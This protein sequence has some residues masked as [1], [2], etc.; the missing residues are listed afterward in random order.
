M[1]I[2]YSTEKI[3]ALSMKLKNI[4][5]LIKY[6]NSFSNTPENYKPTLSRKIEYLQNKVGI[7]DS[8]K[9]KVRKKKLEQKLEKL[10]KI[11]KKTSYLQ[12]IS[13]WYLRPLINHF[14][15][16]QKIETLSSTIVG[17]NALE[18]KPMLYVKEKYTKEIRKS[19]LKKLNQFFRFKAFGKGSEKSQ[20]L[21]KQFYSLF[22]F[23]SKNP[24]PKSTIGD[25]VV[26][27]VYYNTEIFWAQLKN[28]VPSTIV[29]GFCPLSTI[30]DEL[31]FKLKTG[32]IIRPELGFEEITKDYGEIEKLIWPRKPILTDYI[33]IKTALELFNEYQEYP[34]LSVIIWY[35]YHE[36]LL[37]LEEN[38]FSGYLS[39]GLITR[40]QLL[41]GLNS[42]KNRYLKLF[43]MVKSELGLAGR[44][45]KNQ[46]ELVQV[47][48]DKFYE[49]EK[50]RPK[51]EFS[52]FKYIYGSFLGNELR[53]KLYEQLIMK[54][55]LPTLDGNNVL[56]LDTSYE[57]WVDL[58]GTI[59]MEKNEDILKGN[60]SWINYPSLPSIKLSHMREY[61]APHGDKLYLTTD[62]Q[63][64]K[65]QVEKLP[66]KY[67]LHVAPLILGKETVIDNTPDEIIDKLKNKLITLNRSFF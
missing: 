27:L 13:G 44:E 43:E 60:Y 6:K 59:L 24:L 20:E 54:H 5:K 18:Q 65:E 14:D 12:H 23:T 40:K 63:K 28:E 48:E 49:L 1:P 4:K 67:M 21:E 2:K 37:D 26:P 33:K 39:N 46:I 16:A 3:Q 32:E 55:I 36:Y 42:L 38:V 62:P 47:T 58:L 34:N 56:H 52:F 41:R 9:L 10:K 8:K 64:F 22:E 19:T 25:L 66:N 29:T 57:L 45:F 61:N 17:I 31:A 11:Q 35:P 30:N 7:I 50:Y 51:L 15:T 53:R